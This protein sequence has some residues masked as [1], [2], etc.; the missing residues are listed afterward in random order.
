MEAHRENMAPSRE[1][2]GR[3]S[4]RLAKCIDFYIK[5]KHPYAKL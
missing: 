5:Y 3:K 4:Q 1:M 2:P